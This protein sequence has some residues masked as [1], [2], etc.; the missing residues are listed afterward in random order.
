MGSVDAK[1]FESR[2]VPQL[3][4]DAVDVQIVGMFIN[5]VEIVAENSGDVV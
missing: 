1:L 2:V 5:T 4:F 3:L